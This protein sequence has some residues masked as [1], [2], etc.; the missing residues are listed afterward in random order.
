MAIPTTHPV[1]KTARE[2]RRGIDRIQVYIHSN[3]TE[4]S[5][6]NPLLERLTKAYNAVPEN[7]K[8]RG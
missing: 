8:K 6:L 7:Y 3:P 2:L 1:E 4:V 5:Q